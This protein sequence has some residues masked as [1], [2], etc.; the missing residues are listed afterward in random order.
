MTGLADV[1][2][3]PK[4]HETYVLEEYN[5]FNPQ[6]ISSAVCKDRYRYL[7]IYTMNIHLR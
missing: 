4:S 1:N 2:Y 6:I 3:C 5:I 7:F